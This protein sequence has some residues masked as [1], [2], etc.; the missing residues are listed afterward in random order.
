[1]FFLLRVC[2]VAGSIKRRYLN[3]NYSDA[4]ARGQIRGLVNYNILENPSY[5]RALGIDVQF[6]KEHRH[7]ASVH[8]ASAVDLP[9]L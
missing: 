1:M 6:A 3:T 8:E 9:N 4:L 2:C 5:A 7:I